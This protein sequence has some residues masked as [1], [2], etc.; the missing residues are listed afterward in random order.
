MCL[1]CRTRKP[2]PEL[3]RLAKQPEGSFRLDPSFLAEGRG[4]YL[5]KDVQCIEKALKKHRITEALAAEC[6]SLLE[7]EKGSS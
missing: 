6:L 3:I 4:A 5:C 1:L 7:K 2:K